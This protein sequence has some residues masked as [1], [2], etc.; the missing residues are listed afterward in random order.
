[1]F[2]SVADA[3]VPIETQ[4][5]VEEQPKPLESRLSE[6]RLS[7][8]S[9]PLAVALSAS[10]DVESD[11]RYEFI[12]APLVEEGENFVHNFDK[13]G[14]NQLL[15]QTVHGGHK[16]CSYDSGMFSNTFHEPCSKRLSFVKSLEM[17]DIFRMA[18]RSCL[19]RRT[20]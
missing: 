1:M 5:M 17:T 10:P 13:T 18:D 8:L 6:V 16:T 12:M 11:E 14:L 20:R 15:P 9:N 4:T 2:D 7:K 19:S 3:L